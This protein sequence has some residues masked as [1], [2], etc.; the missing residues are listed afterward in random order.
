LVDKLKENTQISF[1][2][3]SIGTTIQAK[4]YAVRPKYVVW[5]R[6]KTYLRG[7]SIDMFIRMSKLPFVTVGVESK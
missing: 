2:D 7:R 5:K 1:I 6:T 4:D 3:D